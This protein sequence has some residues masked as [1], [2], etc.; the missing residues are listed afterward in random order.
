MKDIFRYF[1]LGIAVAMAIMGNLPLFFVSGLLVSFFGFSYILLFTA[2]Y[3]DILY[4]IDYI[5]IG[6]YYFLF[7]PFFLF[8]M[9]VIRIVKKKF[10]W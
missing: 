2:L 8:V 7:T 10:I 6:L 5:N 3:A 4:M 1:I 9:L